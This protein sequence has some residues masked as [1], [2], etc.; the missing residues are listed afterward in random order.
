VLWLRN[1]LMG[2]LLMLDMVV[3]TLATNVTL[4]SR[5]GRTF[6]QMD[7]RDLSCEW[8]DRVGLRCVQPG[9][10]HDLRGVGAG[11]CGLCPLF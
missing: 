11:E 10:S 1:L 6:D 2:F 9:G 4:S 5:R 3:R 7:V 8:H